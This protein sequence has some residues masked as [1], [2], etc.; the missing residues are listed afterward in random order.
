M[1]SC[2]LIFIGSILTA[3]SA[4]AHEPI[5]LHAT[6]ET[7]NLL[8]NLSRLSQEHIIFGHQ[9]AYR[10]GASGGG[11]QWDQRSDIYQVSGDEPALVGFDYREID[12]YENLRKKHR[13]K[14]I[15]VYNRGGILTMSWH[16]KNPVTGGNFHD[17]TEAVKHIIPGGS[18]HEQFKK[19]LDR[20]AEFVQSLRGADGKLIPIIFRPWHEHNGIWF[21]WGQR[22]RTDSEFI[23]L[24]RFTVEYLRDVKNVH[25]LLYAYSPNIS[26][27]PF[28]GINFYHAF[29]GQEYIDIYGVDGYKD[30]IGAF[31]GQA[32]AV[33]ANAQRDGKVAALTETGM[34]G[35]RYTRYWTDSFLKFLKMPQLKGLAYVM[36]WG[37]S[38][39][40]RNHFYAPYLGHH[41]TRDFMQMKQ[42]PYILFQSNLPN[43]YQ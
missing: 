22:H 33:V 3:I 18:K 6:Q 16:A 15:E 38:G 1:K 28:S 41:S 21:W 5:D 31:F 43:M 20:L 7:K 17:K 32:M 14:I 35:V 10:H 9:N 19:T 27:I 12:A 24:W 42:D 36:V 26:M 34:E 13:E 2:L 30:Y 8:K 40:D 4:L 23:S 37:N 25:N 11:W 29:P 39:T